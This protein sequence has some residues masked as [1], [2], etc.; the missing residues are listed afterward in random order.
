[1]KAPTRNRGSK[2][3]RDR[4]VMPDEKQRKMEEIYH[5][6][7]MRMLEDRRA[8]LENAERAERN[9]LLTPSLCCGN[10]SDCNRPCTPR[11]REQA[12]ASSNG[13]EPIHIIFDGPPGP[14]SL[15]LKMLTASASAS[16]DGRKLVTIG[17]WCFTPASRQPPAEP[18]QEKTK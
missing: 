11:G 14:D 17:T 3:G 5:Y 18:T 15:R 6:V 8:L 2:E 1:M 12:F 10:Y 7:I 9:A 13:K 16:V 4:K